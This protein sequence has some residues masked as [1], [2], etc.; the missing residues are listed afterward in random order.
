MAM[1][2]R[3]ALPPAKLRPNA[4][5]PTTRPDQQIAVLHL[6]VLHEL[7]RLGAR[8]PPH[9][10]VLLDLVQLLEGEV[11]VEREQLVDRHARR[12]QRERQAVVR[13]VRQA[14]LPGNALVS[15]NS[16]KFFGSFA[17]LRHAMMVEKY[18]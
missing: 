3:S 16:V 10:D 17:P 13:I 11:D 4:G 18:W 12:L 6:V 14:R 2:D 7:R 8:L 15:K 1:K 9:R 5:S